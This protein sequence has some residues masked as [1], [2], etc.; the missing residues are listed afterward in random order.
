MN[1]LPKFFRIGVYGLLIQNNKVLM[2]KENIQ[3]K[4]VYKFPGGGLIFGEGTKDTLQREFAEELNIKIEILQHIYTTDFF[5]QSAFHKD[6]QVIAIYYLVKSK[7]VL[8][9]NNFSKNNITFLWQTI[10]ENSVNLLKFDTDKKALE[11]LLLF[12]TLK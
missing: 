4:E 1:N 5:V 12:S 3:G 10:D 9:E 8:P 11:T 2:S 7:D 6:Y